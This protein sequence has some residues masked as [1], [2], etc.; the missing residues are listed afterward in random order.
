MAAV[1]AWDRPR[2]AGRPPPAAL[3]ARDLQTWALA[4]VAVAGTAAAVLAA[5]TRRWGVA[6]LATATVAAAAGTVVL[7]R[8]V[9]W[10]QLALW[11]VT[12]LDEPRGLWFAAR[13]D[14]IRFVLVGGEEVEQGPYGVSVVLHTVVAPLVMLATAGAAA[15]LSRRHAPA[16]DDVRGG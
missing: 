4:G 14:A 6:V 7:R 2:P 8:T 13:H 16:R 11:A 12:D 5:T 15:R 1:G 9:L 3:A 10:D